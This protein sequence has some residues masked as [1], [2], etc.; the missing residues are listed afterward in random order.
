MVVDIRGRGDYEEFKILG[1]IEVMVEDIGLLLVVE[2]GCWSL[3]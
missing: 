1:L 3:S 2:W